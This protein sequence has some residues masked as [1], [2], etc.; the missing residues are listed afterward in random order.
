MPASYF[1][2]DVAQIY[3]K[4]GCKVTRK[5]LIDNGKYL[6][7]FTLN[8]VDMTGAVDSGGQIQPWSPTEEDREARDWFVFS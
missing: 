2:Y 1:T 3:L 8:H 7:N 4:S 5:L 6:T